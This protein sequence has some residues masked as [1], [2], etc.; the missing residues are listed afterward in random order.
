[1]QHNMI[2]FWREHTAQLRTAARVAQKA[3]DRAMANRKPVSFDGDGWTPTMVADLRDR[4]ER[5]VCDP[6][7]RRVA[8][9]YGCS[10]ND[11]ILAMVDY[12]HQ[13]QQPRQS[14]CLEH[15]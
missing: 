4:T 15:C 8:A 6:I 2:Q 12:R 14:L 10:H 11:L 5:R 3:C 9:C 1:M 13:P 7:E